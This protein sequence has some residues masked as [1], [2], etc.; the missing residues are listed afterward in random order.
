MIAPRNKF[1]VFAAITLC[2]TALFS[3]LSQDLSVSIGIAFLLLVFFAVLDLFLS[4]GCF[5]GLSIE[6]PEMHQ[7]SAGT[8]KAFIIKIL[9]PEMLESN[10]RIAL[11]FPRYIKSPLEHMDIELLADNAK[12]SYEWPV[13]SEK[14]GEYLVHYVYTERKSKLGFFDMR[15][16]FETKMLLRAYPDLSVDRKSVAALFLNS[17]NIGIHTQRIIGKGRDFEKLREYVPGDSY[18]DIHWKA[19]A[20]RGVPITKVYQIERTQEVYLIIDSSRLSALEVPMKHG[21]NTIYHSKFE[22]YINAALVMAMAAEKQR[23][24]FGIILFDRKVTK[25]IRAKNG[26]AHYNTCR[27]ALFTKE[28]ELSTPD[29]D[30]LCSFIR[31]R[32]TKRALLFF[33]TDLNDPILSESFIKN[34]QLISKQHLVIVNQIADDNV[35]R[36]FSSSEIS[37]L[38]EIYHSLG[39]HDSWMALEELS[40]NLKRFGIRFNLLKNEE[41]CVDLINQYLLVKQRQLI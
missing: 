20:K 3:F 25:F 7:F 2:T 24:N 5:K 37:R 9:N 13:F 26:S 14:R 30:E 15:K 6:L 4:Q 22:R 12:V 33:L 19:T 11:D 18:E 35:K 10:I 39:S 23:D 32:L 8:E 38:S 41:L 21:E 17:G 16:R 40:K 34:I 27:D 36:L 31:S 1:I 28:P 29:Y